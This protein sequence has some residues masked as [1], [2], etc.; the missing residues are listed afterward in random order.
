[1]TDA[2]TDEE[3]SIIATMEIPSESN[4]RSDTNYGNPTEDKMFVLSIN[5]AKQYFDS[6]SARLCNA[7]AY[8]MSLSSDF[9]PDFVNANKKGY[10]IS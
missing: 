4:P 3:Q 9:N 7:T 5:E 1:M 2:F 8:T 6:D 10:V